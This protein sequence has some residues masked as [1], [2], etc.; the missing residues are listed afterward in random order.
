M[1]TVYIIGPAKTHSLFKAF[2][3]ATQIAA[4]KKITFSTGGKTFK[5]VNDALAQTDGIVIFNV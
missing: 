4:Y 3:L 1:K 2:E 5:D